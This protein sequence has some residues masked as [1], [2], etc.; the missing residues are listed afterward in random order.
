MK[1]TTIK[2][3][4]LT[5]GA[6]GAFALVLGASSL[7]LKASALVFYEDLFSGKN[8]AKTYSLAPERIENVDERG[9]LKLVAEREGASARFSD[10]ASGKFS[11]EYRAFSQ[12]NN[13]YDAESLRFVFSDAYTA[14]TFAVEIGL[15]EDG[16]TWHNTDAADLVRAVVDT[17]SGKGYGI[18]SG[19]GAITAYG[20]KLNSSY[21]NLRSGSVVLEFDP[22]TMEVSVGTGNSD[23][24]YLL[25]DLDDSEHLAATGRFDGLSD[26][27][28]Y[29]VD[30]EFSRF[31]ETAKSAGVMIYSLFGNEI[32]G[33]IL[34][35]TQGPG[36]YAKRVGKTL[37]G[38][39]Y[40]G[41]QNVKAYDLLEGQIA[42]DG[43]M[44]ITDPDGERVAAS[45][46]RF[47]PETTGVYTLAYTAKNAVGTYGETTRYCLEVVQNAEIFDFKT[48]RRFENATVGVGSSLLLPSATV[49]GSYAENAAACRLTV[50]KEDETLL[51][52]QETAAETAFSFDTVG[53]YTVTYDYVREGRVVFE[54]TYV[55]TASGDIPAFVGASASAQYAYGTT[56]HVPVRKAVLNGTQYEATAQVLFS[57]GRANGYSQ[58]VLDCKG[59]AELR[60]TALIDGKTYSY[61]EYFTVVKSAADL[62]ENVAG[63]NIQGNTELPDYAD[64]YGNGVLLTSTR[65][66]GTARYA[67]TVDLSESDLTTP[68]LTAMFTPET[69][70]V[71]EITSLQIRMID[72]H[73]ESNYVT[74]LISSVAYGYDYDSSVV[75]GANKNYELVGLTSG[76]VITTTQTTAT[77][78]RSTLKGKYDGQYGC[79]R[80]LPFTIYFDAKSNA[81]YA[82][83]RANSTLLSLVADL[84][85]PKHVGEGNEWHG[86]TTGEVKLEITFNGSLLSRAN[87]T[88]LSVLG[89][90][91]SGE[92]F[93]D[94]VSPYVILKNYDKTSVPNALVGTEYPVFDALLSD[95]AEGE[96]GSV[97]GV[98]VYYYE[99][100]EK[101]E[102][103]VVNGAFTP[104]VSGTHY[105]EYFGSDSAGNAV[106]KTVELQAKSSLPA[107]SYTMQGELEASAYVGETVSL[108]TGEATGG[109]GNLTV[110]ETLVCGDATYP[111]QNRKF[112]F[113][114]AGDYTYR[115]KVTDY[116]GQTYELE[117]SVSVAYSE[118]PIVREKVMPKAIVKGKAYTF[119]EFTAKAYSTGGVQEVP[120]GVTVNGTALAADRKYTPADTSPLEV[121]YTAGAWSK[122]FTVNVTDP[123]S[124][125]A[126]LA[127]YFDY[128]EENIS[129]TADEVGFKVST[130]EQKAENG[131]AS[132]SFINR[133]GTAGAQIEFNVLDNAFERLHIYLTDSSDASVQVKLTVEKSDSVGQTSAFRLNGGYA[134]TMAGSFYQ[135]QTT[136]PFVVRISGQSV[137]DYD[138]TLLDYIDKTVNGEDFEGF[139]TEGVYVDFEFEGVTGSSSILLGRLWNNSFGNTDGDYIE[140][141]VRVDSLSVQPK[142]GDVVTVPR[143]SAFDVLDSTVQ[144][145]LTVVHAKGVAKEYTSGKELSSLVI[146]LNAAYRFVAEEYGSYEIS[147]YAMDG[148]WNSFVYTISFTVE[149]TEAPTLT[150]NGE[151]ESSYEV[152][153]NLSVPSAT[154]TDYGGK[155]LRVYVYLI[156][157]CGRYHD[158]SNGEYV[159]DESGK[160]T[161]VYY[162]YDEF[163][164]YAKREFKI[165]VK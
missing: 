140:P 113:E 11:V 32:D 141:I 102:L 67:N 137:Y 13:V 66:G 129:I 142:L 2:K 26:F 99:Q 136:K 50:K 103:P 107:L 128:A 61:S 109:A 35:A 118:K 147:V 78:I 106:V 19:T 87:L 41:L 89:H 47:T 44:E 131:V 79:L 111:I 100:G 6:I 60:Y 36:V 123:T 101:K 59:E 125:E 108:P 145:E 154:A 153:K 98:S 80:S 157:S 91:M 24:R 31:S 55:V 8:V 119:P 120:V 38:Q 15:T 29:C 75:C 82:G 54:K 49:E 124:E 30:I 33:A 23:L 48:S 27:S 95:G 76:G 70:G 69:M 122:T 115:V 135:G 25:L 158:L 58:V 84:D 12:T 18:D 7:P 62:W 64:V 22:N 72:A 42:F 110:E 97:G 39:E 21:C 73:D 83:P 63:V 96:I 46:G 144:V 126:Y 132:F 164:N 5:C 28:E 1:K 88:V 148:N 45:N 90:D 52:V 14:D 160:Y 43:E 10:A 94:T 146:D 127:G 152:G 20:Q 159:L 86:F 161:V 9:G 4:I 134:R 130:D 112:L 37:V 162:T 93:T 40:D 104:S 165:T 51:R 81:V 74:V 77:K 53:E 155:E 16:H 105:I 56:F 138:S 57:D 92:V 117:R 133:L 163:G 149:A 116:L 114:K 65:S 151:F 68:V 3:G 150:V 71:K 139:S 85:D 121:V 156:D 34:S 17:G 143:I